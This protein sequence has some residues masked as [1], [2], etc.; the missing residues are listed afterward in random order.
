MIV[1][2][3]LLRWTLFKYAMIVTLIRISL[4]VPANDANTEPT[5]PIGLA[6]LA[7]I[8]KQSGVTVQGI[9][10]SGRNLNKIFKFKT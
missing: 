4:S 9:D 5:P 10:A 3:K 7:G 6:Y 2:E 8:C 1:S